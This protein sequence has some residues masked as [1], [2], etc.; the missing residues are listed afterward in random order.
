LWVAHESVWWLALT[1]MHQPADSSS[2]HRHQSADVACTL[3]VLY[4][5][6]QLHKH[7][8]G[9]RRASFCCDTP[10]IITAPDST[11]VCLLNPAGCST[12]SSSASVQ[13]WARTLTAGTALQGAQA[14]AASPPCSL[15]G[16][17]ARAPGL[18]A[19]PFLLRCPAA[20]AAAQSRRSP[21]LQQAPAAGRACP[22]PTCRQR[23]CA[24]LLCRTSATGGRRLCRRPAQQQP[25][26]HLF[27]GCSQ[28][29][30]LDS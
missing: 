18:C 12:W 17:Q 29:R 24:L 8:S 27:L 6:A 30:C 11:H 9:P 7:T 25:L 13:H 5:P 28:V 26:S 4:V 23:P 3:H 10:S 1:A 2:R 15:T 21:A 14:P 19:A 16:L 20:A 22:R